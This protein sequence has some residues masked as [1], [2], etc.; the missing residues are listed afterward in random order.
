[1]FV[2]SNHVNGGFYGQPP[3]L[4]DLDD[5]NLK[6]GLE[7]AAELGIA[8]I[9][10]GERTCPDG[11]IDYENLIATSAPASLSCFVS[12]ASS[13]SLVGKPPPK[14]VSFPFAPITRWHGITIGIGF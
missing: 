7:L 14:P 2:F 11:M 1:M 3:S 12:S 5:G 10:A 13:A 8:T 9:Y 4:T 6:I